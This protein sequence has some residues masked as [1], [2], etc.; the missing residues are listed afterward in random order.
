MLVCLWWAALTLGTKHKRITKSRSFV[1]PENA[2]VT[3]ISPTADNAVQ[4]ESQL[5]FFS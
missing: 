5:L 4:V 3:E 2:A 1:D